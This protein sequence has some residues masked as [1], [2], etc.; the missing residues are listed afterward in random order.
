MK[1]TGIAFTILWLLSAGVARAD[2]TEDFNALLE[3]HWQWTLQ[4][5]KP[6]E[7]PHPPL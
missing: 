6:G 2:A 3:E 1:K 5:Y 7:Q 4:T